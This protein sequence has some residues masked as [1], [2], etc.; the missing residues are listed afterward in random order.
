MEFFSQY[1]IQQRVRDHFQHSFENNRLAHAYLFYGP[2][3]TGKDAFALEVARAL[4]CSGTDIKPCYT[5]VS[6]QKISRFNHPDIHFI[7]PIAKSFTPDKIKDLI[8]SRMENP[9][10]P[11]GTAAQNNILIDQ[12]REL[13]NE[14]KYTPHEA[15]KKVYII[16]DADRMTTEAANSFLK[17]LEEPPDTLTIIL[18]TSSLNA[19]PITIRSRCRVIYFPVLDFQG[20][21]DVI[22]EYMT[23]DENVEKL[24][25]ISENNLKKVFGSLN[26]DLNKQ[27]QIIY[28]FVKAS[29]ARDAFKLF[30]LVDQIT[31]SRDRN[32]LMGLLNLL[33]LWFKD[34]IHVLSLGE[35]ANV[36]N[37]GLRE[38]IVNFA[39]LFTKSD[40]DLIISHIYTAIANI[41][42][43]ANAKIV[44]TALG[45]R[46][47]DNLIRSER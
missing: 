8:K 26:Q 5:C 32:Y 1:K 37:S 30:E 19:I 36:I 6:C 4:N 2:E 45:F 38:N 7:F 35:Q 14:A 29:A 41:Q 9:Y 15:K 11:G 13:K 21:S 20:A 34:V 40:F 44:L 12:I 23:V 18:T 27:S 47:K 42:R 31:V 43:N 39:Q 25:H 46:I 16:S 33:I 24:I 17:I 22:S 10:A 3:G 28:E